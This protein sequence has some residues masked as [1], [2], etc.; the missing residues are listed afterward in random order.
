MSISVSLFEVVF[1][2]TLLAGAYGL[3]YGEAIRKTNK[4]VER[5]GRRIRN[6]KEINRLNMAAT[7]DSMTEREAE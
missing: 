3:G 4:D 5:L 7:V 6:L 1:W 2:A